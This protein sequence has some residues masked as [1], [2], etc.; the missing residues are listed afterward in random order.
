MPK[1]FA[2]Y[3]L[4]FPCS[5]AKTP[6]KDSPALK[7]ARVRTLLP[8]KARVLLLK[9]RKEVRTSFIESFHSGTKTKALDLYNGFQY[10][11]SG[12]KKKVRHAINH[13]GLHCLILSGGFGL[14]AAGEPILNYNVSMPQS[15]KYWKKVLPLVL[16][17]YVKHHHI[18]RVF[19]ASSSS[20]L[21]ALKDPVWRTSAKVWLC[22]PHVA[23]GEGGALIKVPRLTG[24]AIIDLLQQE[25][26]PSSSWKRWR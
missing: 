9:T 26:K 1:P 2:H 5:A 25:C 19:I 8:K 18:K 12:F 11:V 24:T 4:L 6:G 16:A 20:Y 17:A 23:P 13:Q 22:E 10:Q 21:G 14:V 3:L 7:D 15:T